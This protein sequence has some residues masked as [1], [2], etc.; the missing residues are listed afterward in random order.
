MNLKACLK[1][2]NIKKE[3]ENK[4]NEKMETLSEFMKYPIEYYTGY[5]FLIC[6]M[7]A[8]VSIL[9]YGLYHIFVSDEEKDKRLSEGESKKEEKGNGGEK[10]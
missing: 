3:D 6:Y 9:A 5:C 1:Q 4:E 8:W 7:I 2:R 10:L